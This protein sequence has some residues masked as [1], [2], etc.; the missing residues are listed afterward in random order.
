[1]NSTVKKNILTFCICLCTVLTFAQQK[2]E[3]DLYLLQSNFVDLRFGAMIHFNMGTFTDEEWASPRHD[4]KEFNPTKLDCSQWAKACKA[5][6]MTYG[7]L[8]TKHHDGFCLWDSKYTDYDIGNSPLK[9]DVVAEYVKA[10]RKEGLKPCLYFSIWDR[11]NGV[12]NGGAKQEEFVMNQLTELLS[13]YGEIPMIIFDGWN[14]KMGHKSISYQR[15][16]DHIKKLQPNCLVSEHN[17]NSPLQTDLVYYEGPKGVYP[18]GNNVYPSQMALT[19][20]NGWFWHTNAPKEVKDIN[21]TLDKLQRVIPLYCNYMINIGP[22]RE[23]LFDREAVEHLEGVGKRWKKADRLPLPKQPVIPRV[24]LKST[25]VSSSTGEAFIEPKGAAGDG[26]PIADLL[27][28]K[29]A[30]VM[31]DGI[32]DLV[33]DNGGFAAFQTYWKFSPDTERY[34]V[35]DLGSE[36]S[37]SKFYYLPAQ[38]KGYSGIVT[39]YVL[40]VSNDNQSFKAVKSDYWSKTSDL[41]IASFS[42]VKARYI[43]LQILKSIDEAMISEVGAGN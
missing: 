6:G 30:S 3:K 12:E 7:I 10:F 22:N 35:L 37:I 36:E 13:N 31:A 33:G 26:S 32:S 42:P 29:T 5:A 24:Y 39:Q 28:Q 9:R 18:Q 8:T 20:T 17:G 16:Y 15:I 25:I 4:P 43:K 40:S 1:M 41:K 14:W 23:G 21:Y 2:M 19:L 38:L 34:I 27:S 11:H